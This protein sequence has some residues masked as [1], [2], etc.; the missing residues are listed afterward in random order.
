MNSTTPAEAGAQ[1]GDGDN[2][3]H[4]SVT[5]AFP[6]G[7]RPSPG[8]SWKDGAIVAPPYSTPLPPVAANALPL[9]KLVPVSASVTNSDAS[10]AG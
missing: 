1:L 8:W 10:S 5:A 2:D 7:P 4:R 9:V 3:A 6:L